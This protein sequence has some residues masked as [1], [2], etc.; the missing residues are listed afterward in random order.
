M[1]KNGTGGANT[2]AHGLKFEDKTSLAARIDRDLS[3]KYELKRHDPNSKKS[4]QAVD[5]IRKEDQKLIGVLAAKG[6][7]YDLLKE[8]YNL[9]NVDSKEWYPD[10]AFFN[11]ETNT[12]YIIEKKWQQTNGSVDEKLLGFPNKRL[13]YQKIFNQLSKEPKVTVEFGGLFGPSSW[14]LKNDGVS[15]ERYRDTFDILR[16][17]GVRVFFDDYEY[18]W[19]GL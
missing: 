15:V 3:D 13:L 10:E 6:R 8:R 2:N 9:E 17:E 18:W 12:V 11:F 7:F 4:P 5:V 16:M 19:F 14:W 1:K